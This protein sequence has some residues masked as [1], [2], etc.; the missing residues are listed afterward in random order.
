MIFLTGQLTALG[1]L[2]VSPLPAWAGLLLCSLATALFILLVYKVVSNQKAI[3]RHKSRI[4]GHFLSIYL[5]R[6]SPA[7]ILRSLGRVLVSIACYLGFFLPPLIIVFIPVSLMLAQLELRY[8]HGCPP[9]GG[10]AIVRVFV[11]KGTDLF[12]QPPSLSFEGGMETVSPPLR[13][14]SKSEIDWKV[15]LL[16]TGKIPFSL[17]VAGETFP[18]RLDLSPGNHPV[19]PVRTKPGF[20][21][22]VQYPGQPYL[23]GDGPIRRVEF[24]LPGRE[25]DLGFAEAHWVIIYFVLTIGLAFGLKKPF[26]VEF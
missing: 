10:T 2:I 17:R 7:L 22:A 1:D 16:E 6:D 4:F 9:V 11:E 8:G 3:A 5:Y 20:W 23:P 14:E 26:R 19:Y 12:I 13:M 24:E 25:I 18:G 15:R 21:A